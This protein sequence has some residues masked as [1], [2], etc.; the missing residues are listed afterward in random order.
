MTA[1]HLHHLE[2]PGSAKPPPKIEM[3]SSVPAPPMPYDAEAMTILVTL[4]PGCEGAP[5]HRHTGPAFGYVLKGAIVFELEGEPERVV[6][7]GESFWEPGGDVIH[8]QDGN[9]FDDAES[10]FVVTM[11][12]EPGQPMLIPVSAEELE[13]RRD[14]RAPRP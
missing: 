4:P 14:R 13:E 12:G 3:V 5:P 10:Q 8:Y 1:D 11:F 2:N 7:A 9:H 6:K